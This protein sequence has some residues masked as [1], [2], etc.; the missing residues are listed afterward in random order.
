MLF[1]S[2]WLAVITGRSREIYYVSI[3]CGP[4]SSADGPHW[5]SVM[6]ST[7]TPSLAV[8]RAANSHAFDWLPML[9]SHTSNF[10]HWIAHQA[11][12]LK[13]ECWS[14]GLIQT[15]FST[16]RARLTNLTRP[17]GFN[18]GHLQTAERGRDSMPKPCPLWRYRMRRK[19]ITWFTNMLL[20]NWIET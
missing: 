2:L 20:M 3:C 10:S 9:S 13:D 12:K 5:T 6:S 15:D 17:M 7:L 11:W 8:I 18:R 19:M 4:P 16:G 1:V 14:P